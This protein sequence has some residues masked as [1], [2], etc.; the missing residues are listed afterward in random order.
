MI[1]LPNEGAA[2]AP[3]TEASVTLQPRDLRR[4]PTTTAL[5]PT[6]RLARWS[7]ATGVAVLALKLLAW[8]LTDSVALLSDALESVVNVLAAGAMLVAVRIA[9]SPADRGH[10]YGHG[11]AEYLSAV[12][13]GA[14]ILAAAALCVRAGV[15]RFA[16]PHALDRPGLGLAVSL[17][18]TAL[19]AALAWRLMAGGRTLRSP[20]L[21]ADGRHVLSD[22]TT[23]GGVLAGVAIAWGTGAWW[24]DPLMACAFG[25]GVLGMG[26]GLVRR[27]VGGLMDEVMDPGEVAAARAIAERVA[28]EDGALGVEGLRLRRAGPNGH[29]DLRLLVPATMRVREAHAICDRI[30]GALRAWDDRLSVIV[31]V[32]PAQDEEYPVDDEEGAGVI[33]RRD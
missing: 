22:V 17:V 29:C 13:E 24:V 5:A 19:N 18:A 31:H 6:E 33:D 15:E 25:A 2:S 20:A 21:A 14:L 8:R 32:E 9:R 12:F 3:I 7:L 27:S 30:E 16:H 23:T 11:K 26:W 4:R 28:R 10:P 1:A